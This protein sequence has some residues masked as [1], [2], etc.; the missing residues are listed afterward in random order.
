[1]QYL[2]FKAMVL[3]TP[4]IRFCIK[5][6][7]CIFKGM[8]LLSPGIQPSVCYKFEADVFLLFHSSILFQVNVKVFNATFNNISAISWQS[9]L[10]LEEIGVPGEN[11]QHVASHCQTLSHDVVSSTPS[12]ERDTASCACGRV[13]FSSV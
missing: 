1:M 8:V 10:S 6:N 3:L 5:Y 9:V 4:E 13:L 7:T 11:H 2:F 12:H